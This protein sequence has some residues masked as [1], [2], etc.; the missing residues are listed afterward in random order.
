MF[1]KFLEYR[2]ED[3]RVP[4]REWYDGQDPAVRAAFDAT[5]ITLGAATDWSGL[6]EVKELERQHAGLTEFIVEVTAKGKKR[7]YRVAVL[8]RPETFECILFTGCEKSGRVTIPPGA[9]DLALTYKKWLEQRRGTT[10]EY[11]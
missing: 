1:W 3:R 11:I 8:C 7:H 4:I 9:F 5:L 6:G 2:T 10:H